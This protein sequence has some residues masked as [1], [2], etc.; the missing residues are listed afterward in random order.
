MASSSSSSSSSSYSSMDASASILTTVCNHSFHIDCLARW[1]DSPCPVCRYDHSGLNET[2]SRCI[3]C[4]TTYRN[5][6]CLI[7]GLI[8]CANGRMS[9]TSTSSAVECADA[10]VELTS[11]APSHLGHALR[12]Y[13]EVGRFLSLS[14]SYSLSLSA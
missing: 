11:Q 5:Y 14:L 10:P 13:E 6:V 7:C 4:G 12:H 2:L 1:Q 3:V 9:S 8:S